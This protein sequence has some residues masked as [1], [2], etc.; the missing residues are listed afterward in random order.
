MSNFFKETPHY[1]PQWMYHFTFPPRVQG[2][3]QGNPTLV[4]V[5]LYPHQ[6]MLFSV[7]LIVAILMGMR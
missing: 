4:P 5:S 2:T 6:H 7:P 1:F 3:Q